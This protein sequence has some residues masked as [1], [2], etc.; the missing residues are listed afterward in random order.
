MYIAAKEQARQRDRDLAGAYYNRACYFALSGE[1]GCA[2]ED[3]KTSLSLSP[4][5]FQLA[6]EDADLSSLREQLPG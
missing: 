4:D 6:T 2:L 3:L 5:N 1:T